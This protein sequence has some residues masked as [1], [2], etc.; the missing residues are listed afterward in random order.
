[1]QSDHLSFVL[2]VV[3]L[4]LFLTHFCDT[5]GCSTAF[6]SQLSNEL[7]LPVSSLTGPTRLVTHL[8]QTNT[9]GCGHSVISASIPDLPSGIP[10]TS[11]FTR[12]ETTKPENNSKDESLIFARLT[13]LVPLAN[14]NYDCVGSASSAFSDSPCFP[15]FAFSLSSSQFLSVHTNR[16]FVYTA[17]AV[18]Q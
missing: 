12:A 17:V 2:S 13:G 4:Q 3:R 8:L 14:V 9:V 6:F 5:R 15:Y 18:E 7:S 10:S 11:E 16:V 1:M